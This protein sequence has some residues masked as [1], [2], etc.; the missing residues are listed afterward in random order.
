MFPNPIVNADNPCRDA[1]GSS[2]PCSALQ[3]DVL[4]NEGGQGVCPAELP[5]HTTHRH[6]IQIKIL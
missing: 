5:A 1:C 3:W 4:V 2:S 6:K